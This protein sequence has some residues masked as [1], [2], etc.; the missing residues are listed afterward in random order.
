MYPLVLWWLLDPLHPDFFSETP[1]GGSLGVIW[2]L[3]FITDTHGPHVLTEVI[4]NSLGKTFLKTEYYC[5][6]WP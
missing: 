4:S 3:G 2:L 5:P 1:A 6:G